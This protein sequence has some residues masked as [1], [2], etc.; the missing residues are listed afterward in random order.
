MSDY[1]ECYFHPMIRCESGRFSCSTCENYHPAG[2]FQMSRRIL[3]EM[4]YCW[5][6]YP[7]IGNF[8]IGRRSVPYTR[9]SLNL[10][11]ILFERDVNDSEHDA[12][13][14]SC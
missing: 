6:E 11:E 9:N 8:V 1:K 4:G 7:V 12:K 2:K 3:K 13:S 5:I 14:Y 10:F